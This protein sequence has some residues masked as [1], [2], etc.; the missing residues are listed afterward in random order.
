VAS[1]AA[2]P[3][4]IV[5]AERGSAR[6]TLEEIDAYIMSLPKHL[7]AG[8]LDDPQR[9]ENVIQ[10][11]M[12]N[13]Q[14]AAWAHEQGIANDPHYAVQVRMAQDEY[15]AKR[16]RTLS[17]DQANEN[18]P[19]FN[20]IAEEVFLTHPSRFTSRITLQLEH[21]LIRT[22]PRREA[23]IMAR[24]EE[25]R[26]A[27][28]QPGSDF[29]EI[30][31]KYSDEFVGAPDA[32][33]GLLSDVIPGTM[34]KPF[35][36][37]A[38]ALKTPGDVTE[39]TRTKY[40]LHVARLISRKEAVPQ[41]FEEVRDVLIAEQRDVYVRNRRGSLLERL[42]SEE[43]NASQP[44]VAQLRTRYA[45]AAEGELPPPVDGTQAETPVSAQA[46]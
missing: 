6:V 30:F 44:V 21:I 15:L 23:E 3:A 17:E 34:E 28:Q 38:F 29:A 7:R 22:D 27:L 31:A 12:M 35:N 33:M 46:D 36:D 20:V 45:K 43:L 2:T 18:L 11:L 39:V 41:K 26:A 24:A 42:N 10:T 5:V 8:F 16:A 4:E 9:I 37:A 1:F 40:G 14:L 19:D 13:E 32:S 25:A